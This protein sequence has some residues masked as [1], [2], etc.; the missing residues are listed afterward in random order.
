MIEVWRVPVD[1]REAAGAALREIL[2]RF[3]PLPLEFATTKSGKPYLAGVPLL[4]F[5]LSH[6]RGIAL[7][8]VAL[9]VDVGVDVER[10]RSV[11]EHNAI[12]ERFFPA[13]E[14]GPCTGERDFFQR[15][16]RV[17]AV[18]KARGVGLYGAGQEPQGDWTIRELDVGEPYA[19][20][21]AAPQADLEVRLRD[22]IPGGAPNPP[23][24]PE[25]P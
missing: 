7:V 24:A 2:A 18:L 4:R 19:A 20:A 1:G 12:I 14:S 8:A 16:T 3:T 9:D 25:C 23:S 10:I 6:T 13:S 22:F 21:V 15:W 5:N 17:E 11:P